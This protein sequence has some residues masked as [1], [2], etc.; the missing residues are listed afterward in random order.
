MLSQF[1]ENHGAVIFST[2]VGFK[3]VSSKGCFPKIL[4]IYSDNYFAEHQQTSGRDIF[5]TQ[6]SISTG[7]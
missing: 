7:F 6:S 4:Q 5:K 3:N 1:P 2:I